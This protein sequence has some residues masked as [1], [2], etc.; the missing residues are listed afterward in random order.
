MHTLHRHVTSLI[1]SAKAELEGDRRWLA[2]APVPLSERL[3]FVCRKYVALVLAREHVSVLGRR[4]ERV[5]L[6][7]QD[8]PAERGARLLLALSERI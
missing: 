7:T 4:I 2:D 5:L 1:S 8:A 3:M 6:Q